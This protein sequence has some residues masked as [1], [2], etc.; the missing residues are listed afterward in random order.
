[1]KIYYIFFIMLNFFVTSTLLAQS[2]SRNVN[3]RASLVEVQKVKLINIAETTV[4]IGRLVALDPTIISA[5]I[6]QE[7]LKV[8]FQI[9]D[10]IRKNDLLVTLESKDILRNIKQIS[11]E[12]LLENQ[13]V[14]LLKKQ[15]ELRLSKEKNA[16]NLKNQKIIT[17][18]NLDTISILVLQNQQQIAQREYNI[19]KLKILIDKARDDLKYSKILSPINGNII[20]LD[21]KKGALIQKGKVIASILAEGSK[22]IE[23]DLRAESAARVILGSKVIISNNK[24]VFNGKIRGIV[25]IENIR[26]GTRKVRVALDKV[27]PK[28]LNVEGTRFSLKIPVG[29]NYPR[30]LIHKDA[31]ISKGQK[32]IVYIF[33][34]GLA[35]QYFV[36]IGLSIGNNIEITDGI[37]EGQLVVIKG[38]ENLRPNQSIKIKKK[39][40]S[41]KKNQKKN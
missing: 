14:Q 20:L 35:K 10:N 24:S 32:Q 1:M 41:Y 38:N 7:V 28:T 23:T 18:D 25:N 26:T 2:T 11:S 17:Q 8:H 4:T 30:L 39:N 27:L 40:K 29:K 13:L 22:E 5:K 21:I 36:K 9:G 19:K 6:N 12:L 15:L 33:D 37:K 31:L 16:E 3:K 34:K